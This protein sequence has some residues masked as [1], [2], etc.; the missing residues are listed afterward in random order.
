VLTA[1]FLGYE[2]IELAAT[3]RKTN[4]MQLVAFVTGSIQ[5][6]RT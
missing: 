1:I 4:P 6:L 3:I 2:R 5:Q